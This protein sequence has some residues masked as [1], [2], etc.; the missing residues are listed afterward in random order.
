MFRTP[1]QS[2]AKEWFLI[3]EPNRDHSGFSIIEAVLASTL[4]LLMATF[5][6]SGYLFSQENL[7]L[8]GNR[9][10]AAL[11]ATEGLEAVRNIQDANFSNLANGTYGL[12][13]T[14]QQWNFSGASDTVGIYKRAITISTIDSN[15][16]KAS[17][18]VTW[19]Q[20]T[21]RSGGVTL[22][23]Y[24]TNW[25]ATT[26][27][28]I[29]SWASSTIVGSLNIP[30]NHT[31]VKVI[32]SGGQ[33]FVLV[34]DTSNNFFTISLATTTPTITGQTSV[35]NNNGNMITDM[36]ATGT[37]VFVTTNEQT[38]EIE[39]VNISNP[40]APSLADEFNMAGNNIITN[41]SIYG[42][43]DYLIAKGLKIFAVDI[44]STTNPLLL[45][46]Y[47]TLNGIPS[48]VIA[49]KNY[50]YISSADNTRELQV[51]STADPA[52]MSLADTLDLSGNTDAN[53]LALYGT[54]TY[55]ARLDGRIYPV[56]VTTPTNVTNSTSFQI[57]S[58][59]IT[60]NSMVAYSDGTNTYLAMMTSDVNGEVKIFD[61]TNPASPALLKTFNI[62]GSSYFGPGGIAYNADLGY[63]LITGPAIPSNN[64]NQ[65]MIIAPQ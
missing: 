44:S 61:V 7:V 50:A 63:L 51:I 6:I 1:S 31:G 59:V 18:T 11:V 3:K 33:A 41:S 40:A 46:T 45:D 17:A 15:R 35:Y 5:L 16:K 37:S 57:G 52:H 56:N 12:S 20:N 54:T 29:P 8:S 27:P 64:Y 9:D 28:I 30:G 25:T 53:T 13:T 24:F 42:N 10:Q 4:L 47:L 2:T 19:N 23:T 62:G 39:S 55:V 21:Q 65:L 22:E 34:Q 26:A 32:S 58:G 60:A 38:H 49:T 43:I 14:S 48:D 36:A